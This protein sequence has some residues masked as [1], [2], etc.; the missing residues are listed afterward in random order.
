MY[1]LSI[2]LF[3][4]VTVPMWALWVALA[5]VIAGIAVLIW[6]QCV[7]VAN[8]KLHTVP[9]TMSADG[10]KALSWAVDRI[11]TGLL[12]HLREEIG[13]SIPADQKEIY[14]FVMLHYSERNTGP[15]ISI[16]SFMPFLQGRPY[17]YLQ[18]S[19]SV[20]GV[21]VLPVRFSESG[22][23]NFYLEGLTVVYRN[24]QQHVTTTFNIRF[25]SE[26]AGLP[27]EEV[28]DFE[29]ENKTVS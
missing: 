20:G 1:L 9:Q 23:K 22:E 7:R 25:L 28:L 12:R 18:G 4:T 29:F 11:K 5:V 6:A 17:L 2:T 15:Y 8:R 21:S 13:Q 26:K 10:S 24:G 14:R 16:E 19:D 27:I 3:D